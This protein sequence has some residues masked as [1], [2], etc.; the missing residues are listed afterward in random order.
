MC[1][2]KPT[3]KDVSN[4]LVC[5]CPYSVV[6]Q[7]K[8]KV[9][10]PKFIMPEL[11][12]KIPGLTLSPTSTLIKSQSEDGSYRI[13]VPWIAEY[14]KAIYNYG[15]GIVGILAALV[16][17]G[18][19]VL[20]LISGGDASKNTQAKEMIIGSV[21]G[22]T[23]LA[24]SYIILFQ[25]NPELTKLKPISLGAI[26]RQDFEPDVDSSSPL[27][28]DLN[29][30]SKILGVTCGK[31]SVAEIVNK[32]KGKVTYANYPDRGKTGPNNTVYND[33]SGFANFVLKCAS[34]KNSGSYTGDIFKE[35]SVWDMDLNKLQPG[36]L[37]GW[38]PK[39]N[40]DNFGHVIIYLG[41]GK[42]GDC[43][44][45]DR[46]RKPGNC[47]SNNISF[48]SVKN[49]SSKKSDGKLYFKRY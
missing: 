16:L 36:D 14:I 34:N 3:G 43:H 17:M 41:N 7:T 37:V 2:V 32:S 5:C 15:L 24:C 33:C 35:Q 42:F 29:G 25:V 30:I 49:Y 23:I 46:G 18:G 27:S 6:N 21:T 39:N 20:W 47:I 28:L 11:Q 44:G 12:I 48:E 19:G 38:A 26:E 1:G 22:L 31:D 9:E 8:P 10:L 40:K 45:G 4:T 13:E